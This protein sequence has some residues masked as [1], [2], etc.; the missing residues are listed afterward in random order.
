[1]NKMEKPF[2][3]IKKQYDALQK[4]YNG[5]VKAIDGQGAALEASRVEVDL[6]KRQLVNADSRIAIYKK[7]MTDSIEQNQEINNGLVEEVLSLKK[8]IKKLRGE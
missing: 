6:L 8:T 2:P 4:R 3:I 7:I 5:L 1:M